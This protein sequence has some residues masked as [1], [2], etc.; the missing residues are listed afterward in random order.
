[1]KVKTL[2]TAGAVMLA[3]ADADAIVARRGLMNIS[4][5]DGTT[6]KAYIQGDEYHHVY[7]SEDSCVLVAD[8]SQTLCYAMLDKAG[9]L[10]SSGIKA[11]DIYMRSDE[12]KAFLGTVSRSE[13]LK[14]VKSGAKT[15]PRMARVPQRLAQGGV[16]L[17]TTSFPNT[18]DVP[19]CVLI[20]S[21][22]DVDFTLDD[23]YDYFNRL[24][25][26]DEFTDYGGT[27]SA[28]QYFI[29]QSHGAFRPKF[30]LYGPVKLPRRR[31]HYGSND[32]WGNDQYA[33]QMVTDALSILDDEVDFS[34]Y[35]T[36]GD[37]YIDNI[38][39]FYAGGGEATGGG[40]N[41]VW[42]HSWDID[43]ANVGTYS[44]D[45]VTVNHYACSNEWEAQSQKPGGIGTFVH[46]F[47]HVLGLPDLYATTYTS[48]FT[49][50]TW[51]VL[52]YGPYNNDGRTP[53][54]YSAYER[55]ALG[56]ME[57]KVL[58]EPATV[59]MKPI[60]DSNEAY[61][62]PT[63]KKNEFFL[64]ENRQ[65]EG[66]D[67]FI[68]GHGMLVWHIDYVQSVWDGN[69]VNNTASHQY[70]DLEEANNSTVDT[71]TARAGNSF[72]GTGNKTSFT[73]DTAPSMRTWAGA[74]LN[75]PITGITESMDG[76][77]TFDVCGGEPPVSRPVMSEAT[78]IDSEGFTANWMEARG[79][80]DYILR[81]D[82]TVQS[83]TGPV[84]ET[85][86]FTGSVTNA[87]I[88]PEGWS[89]NVTTVYNSV[90]YAGASKPSLQMKTDGAFVETRDMGA[91]INAMSMWIRGV[92][93][94]EANSVAIKGLINDK[95]ET[96]RT[97]NPK[98]YS[99]GEEIGIENMP[100]GVRKMRV[101]FS[102]PLSGVM[103]LDDFR[104]MSDGEYVY[105][106]P[107]YEGKH[108]GNV[109]SFRVTGLPE[110]VDE[111]SY[112]VAATNGEY[113]TAFSEPCVVKRDMSVIG[114]LDF[115][116]KVVVAATANGVDIHGVDG[117]S[118]TVCDMQG[119]VIAAG[120]LDASGRMNVGLTDGI[121]V[122]K[123]GHTVVK[124][125]VK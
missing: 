75:I 91:D 12:A 24:L 106:V 107:G 44:Y 84:S 57:P 39:V 20:V 9:R 112:S 118:V 60:T 103:A 37:G 85:A 125:A 94:S 120:T 14:A 64:V 34:K 17:C 6:V 1:M 11:S 19:A 122:V 101:E 123:A 36:D 100:A 25:N 42:P 46:E 45:G 49:P 27:G 80:T 56:W 69:K 5:P 28:R 8:E 50:G 110:G 26:A 93:T 40:A 114:S 67:E 115:N 66:W 54:A 22:S 41:S 124:V 15:S 47:S 121:Y 48:A 96:L 70:V 13:L 31:S 68:P 95:W 74:A 83:E 30:D 78:E 55:N 62:I 4:Q 73:D 117:M 89:T 76:Y 7:M 86:D 119:R 38:Y 90:E 43:A 92:G 72:P 113:T 81:V 111:F 29:D 116:D 32:Y 23:P 109:L 77:V 88:V 97:E 104:I 65:Q 52:D 102:R 58:G 99:S 59:S 35:D 18:G 63:S 98:N 105:A 53:P 3:V 51:S 33:W 79:A 87:V 61:I 10:V 2:L 71:P 108:T 21:Y 82:Y 16:G